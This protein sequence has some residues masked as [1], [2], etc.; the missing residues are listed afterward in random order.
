[1]KVCRKLFE[2]VE[3]VAVQKMHYSHVIDNTRIFYIDTE[4]KAKEKVEVTPLPEN[5]AAFLPFNKTTI[6]LSLPEGAFQLSIEV[7]LLERKGK[8]VLGFDIDAGCFI[9]EGLIDLQ[10]KDL[11]FRTLLL[12]RPATGLLVDILKEKKAT[13][14]LQNIKDIA[15]TVLEYIYELNTLDR[16][17]VEV[18]TKKKKRK[19]GKY[20]RP[21]YILLRPGEI[22]KK[23]G[24]KDHQGGTKRVHERRAH[25]RKYPDDKERFPNAHGKVV[26]IPAVWVGQS[27]GTSGNK[28]YKVILS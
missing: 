14:F 21:E 22:R 5:T 11:E 9:G 20:T 16:F 1:M 23:L 15:K 26:Q 6:S 27:E 25:L 19:G 12:Y 10:E 7:P 4:A 24:I 8:F 2:K 28:H 18:T 17:I 13:P 3:R